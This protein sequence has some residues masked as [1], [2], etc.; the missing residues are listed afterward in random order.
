MLLAGPSKAGKSFALI[1]L[2]VATAEGRDWIGF[3]CAKGKALYVNLELD[4]APC[5][6][7]FRYP[8]H[9]PDKTGVLGDIEPEETKAPWQR[10]S[11]SNASRKEK[12]QIDAARSSRKP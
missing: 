3:T 7:R 10:G 9:T 11:E 4:H 2:C 5:L 8:L 1:E 6:H 12:L